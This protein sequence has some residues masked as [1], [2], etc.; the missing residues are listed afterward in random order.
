M[1]VDAAHAVAGARTLAPPAAFSSPPAAGVDS[2][3]LRTPLDH[4]HGP[5]VG[6]DGAL[7]AGTHT[8][9]VALAVDSEVTRV[10]DGSQDLMGFSGV[11]GTDRLTS[12]G[13]PG[14]GSSMLGAAAAGSM[15]RCPT[16]TTRG[17][18]LEPGAAHNGA[19]PCTDLDRAPSCF[20]AC[21]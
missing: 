14:P 12:S 17:L 10:G 18:S 19:V 5:L 16:L 15:R 7:L 9:V 11:P 4:V 21:R 13:H 6:S 3:P 8:G 1:R 2:V 20:V